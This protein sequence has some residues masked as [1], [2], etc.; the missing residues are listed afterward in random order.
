M[1]KVASQPIPLFPSP[2]PRVIIPHG[3]ELLPG[4]DRGRVIGNDIKPLIVIK[5]AARRMVH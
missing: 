3:E 2:K 5:I 4:L 1:E